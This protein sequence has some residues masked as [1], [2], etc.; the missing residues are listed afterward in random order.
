MKR[1]PFFKETI[2][3]LD[4][5]RIIGFHH[6]LDTEQNRM[7]ESTKQ[8]RFLDKISM[9]HQ[10][11]Q[12]EVNC[13]FVTYIYIYV[14]ICLT[15]HCRYS[16]DEV[17]WGKR[18]NTMFI[19]Y[20][21]SLGVH[22]TISPCQSIPLIIPIMAHSH[23]HRCQRSNLCQTALSGPASLLERHHLCDGNAM[24]RYRSLHC[25]TSSGYSIDSW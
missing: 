11:E 14:Y 6:K 20:S 24:E 22:I 2:D 8:S 19:A 21:V 10:Y 3:H 13:I 12:I 9:A 25:V 15:R 16:Y 23:F 4:N 1:F 18:W 7:Y 5:Y 17:C